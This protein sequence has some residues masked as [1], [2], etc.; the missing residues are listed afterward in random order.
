MPF[1]SWNVQSLWGIFRE[2]LKSTFSTM[3]LT[4]T[5][6]SDVRKLREL[7]NTCIRIFS[8]AIMCCRNYIS[9]ETYYLWWT[10]Q[11]VITRM[12]KKK[13]CPQKPVSFFPSFFPSYIL[14]WSSSIMFPEVYRRDMVCPLAFIR[15]PTELFFLDLYSFAMSFCGFVNGWRRQHVPQLCIASCASQPCYCRD[16]WWPKDWTQNQTGPASLRCGRVRRGGGISSFLPDVLNSNQEKGVDCPGR[17]FFSPNHIEPQLGERE[18]SPKK[19]LLFSPHWVTAGRKG[20]ITQKAVLKLEN[21]LKN[22]L[23]WCQIGIGHQPYRVT[24]SK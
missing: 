7:N 19:R 15:N 1:L 21:M 23:Y 17:G 20:R 5:P 10:M 11:H 18:D 2:A 6:V 4:A 14:W 13:S 3:P 9:Q 22:K 12:S 24:A 16:L 8:M